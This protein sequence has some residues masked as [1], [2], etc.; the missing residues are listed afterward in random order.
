MIFNWKVIGNNFLVS[1]FFKERV[2]VIDI[3]YSNSDVDFI[4]MAV[5][6][7]LVRGFYDEFVNFWRGFK[8]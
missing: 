7:I 5:W 3:F 1:Y 4:F 8:I 2:V 6:R